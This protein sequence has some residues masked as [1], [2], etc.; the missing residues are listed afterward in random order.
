MKEKDDIEK[1]IETK[2]LQTDRCTIWK[3]RTADF[4]STLEYS[5]VQYNT[6]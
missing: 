5:V 4:N 1:I 6:I 2:M 3:L